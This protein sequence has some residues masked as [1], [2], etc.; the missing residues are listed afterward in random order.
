MLK[1]VFNL[2]ENEVRWKF[3]FIGRN[4]NYMGKYKCLCLF[5]FYNLFLKRG[6]F[7]VREHN[8]KSLK[9]I[10]FISRGVD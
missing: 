5:I 6:W 1:D 7:R 2:K 8:R 9:G 10:N 4:R 3:I